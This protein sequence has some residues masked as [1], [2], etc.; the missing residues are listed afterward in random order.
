[1]LFRSYVA[2]VWYLAALTGALIFGI[3]LEELLFA[4]AFGLY[5]AGAYEHFT[6][7]EITRAPRAP[8]RGR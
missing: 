2:R 3:P 6:W 4:A 8:P 5:W 7:T 1:M